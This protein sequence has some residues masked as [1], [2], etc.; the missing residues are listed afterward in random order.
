MTTSPSEVAR[1]WKGTAQRRGGRAGRHSDLYSTSRPAGCYDG[2]IR[3]CRGHDYPQFRLDNGPE[4]ALSVIMNPRVRRRP[5]LMV[6]WQ[7]RR[8]SQRQGP[9]LAPAR[10]ARRP[11]LVRPA[12]PAPSGPILYADHR[13]D[14]RVASCHEV[15]PFQ[16]RHKHRCR[17]STSSHAIR[18]A[19]DG[20]LRGRC[21]SSPLNS[22]P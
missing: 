11:G 8:S 2:P 21:G 12:S 10:P 18:P 15:P 4:L 16:P 5:S 7:P 19:P 20:Q 13:R 9:Q 22:P 17:R 14:R 1:W 6:A 3:M